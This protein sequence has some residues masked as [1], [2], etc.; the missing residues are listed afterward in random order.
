L[1]V[2]GGR[3][4]VVVLLFEESPQEA[5]P[6]LRREV[7]ES[8]D[9]LA[10]CLVALSAETGDRRDEKHRIAIA[11]ALRAVERIRKWSEGGLPDP[12]GRARSAGG[13]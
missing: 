2:E 1:E 8:L 7:H 6:G 3:V 4:G 5:R 13:E 9:E 11:E 12:E 10:H